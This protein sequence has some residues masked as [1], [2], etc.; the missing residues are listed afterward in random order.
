MLCSMLCTLPLEFSGDFLEP[1]V[2]QGPEE[3][4]RK[5]STR[6][7]EVCWLGVHLIDILNCLGFHRQGRI[8]GGRGREQWATLPFLSAQFCSCLRGHPHIENILELL[9]C[10]HA[11]WK[12]YIHKSG[13]LCVI[14]LLV[15]SCST[16]ASVDLSNTVVL[17][18][19]IIINCSYTNVTVSQVPIPIQPRPLRIAL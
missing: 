2:G 5:C 6:M 8:C 17:V 19:C 13:G 11:P 10:Y 14:A 12:A 18:P 4:L 7:R 1:F 16:H 3:V 9:P 15:C